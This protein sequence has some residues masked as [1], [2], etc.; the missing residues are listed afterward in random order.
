MPSCYS[1]KC[2]QPLIQSFKSYLSTTYSAHQY[3]SRAI[4]GTKFQFHNIHIGTSFTN[5]SIYPRIMQIYARI[6]NHKSRMGR[7]CTWSTLMSKERS[8]GQPLAM[9]IIPASPI[10]WQPLTFRWCSEQPWPMATR[11][12]SPTL[13]IKKGPRGGCFSQRSGRIYIM[14]HVMMKISTGKML[15]IGGKISIILK[16]KK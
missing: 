8:C 15:T 13:V 12:S 16:G 2:F 3:N 11:A 4:W 14:F 7:E 1:I 5:Q 10:W 9:A 6:H